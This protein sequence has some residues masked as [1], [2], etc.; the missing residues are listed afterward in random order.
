MQTSIEAYALVVLLAPVSLA[1]SWWLK[2]TVLAP[3]H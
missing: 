3:S 2:L 1:A